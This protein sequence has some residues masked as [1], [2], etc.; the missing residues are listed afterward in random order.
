MDLLKYKCSFKLHN[1]KFLYNNNSSVRRLHKMIKMNLIQRNYPQRQ[2]DQLS[3]SDFKIEIC[4]LY[5]RQR[6]KCERT[7]FRFP[8]T[9][10]NLILKNFN[11]NINLIV[12]LKS[13][14]Y[15]NSRKI[16]RHFMHFEYDK[17]YL[18]PLT[19]KIILIKA[20]S[21]FV[22]LTHQFEK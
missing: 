3:F 9:G 20:Y 17:S 1:V 13:I 4:E 10:K 6:E 21:D 12:E 8:S 5:S 18:T 15:T 2:L 16:S 19:V 11:L 7:K 22:V 14:Q